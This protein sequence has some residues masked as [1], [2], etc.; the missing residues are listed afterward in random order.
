METTEPSL[1]DL[2]ERMAKALTTFDQLTANRPRQTIESD[3]DFKVG[4]T[5]FRAEYTAVLT[6]PGRRH[7]LDRVTVE[8]IYIVSEDGT[9]DILLPDFLA[10]ELCDQA[11]E[12]ATADYFK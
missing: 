1:A 7:E 6:Y 9:H 2:M 11:D 4:Q 8:D 12:A 10:S 5:T 3:V